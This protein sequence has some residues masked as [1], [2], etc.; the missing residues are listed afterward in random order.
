[1]TVVSPV[2]RDRAPSTDRRLGVPWALVVPLAALFAAVDGFWAASMRSAVG[3][4]ERTPAPFE[5]W[6][7]QTVVTLPL[8]VVAVVAAL[9]LAVRWFGPVPRGRRQLWTGALVALAGAVVGALVLALGAAVD[10]RLQQGHVDLMSHMTPGCGAPC[11][12]RIE[13][14]GVSTAVRGVAWGTGLVVVSNLAVVAWVMAALGG[15]LPVTRRS[16]QAD[17]ARW[18][19]RTAGLAAALAGSAAIHL[20]V[21]PEHLDEWPLA[22]AFF[23][24]LAAGEGGA[25]VAVLRGRRTTPPEPRRG[26]VAA[27]EQAGT[28]LQPRRGA[29]AAG[30][31]AGTRPQPRRGAV[32]AGDVRSHRLLIAAVLLGVGPLL[33][34]LVSRTVGLPFGP[35]AGEVEAVG[36]A[37]LA[38]VA[39]ELVTVCL[40]ARMLLLSTSAADPIGP[41]D[42]RSPAHVR[43]LAVT[44]VL[45]V[46]VVGCAGALPD[47]LGDVTGPATTVTV[48]DHG[49]DEGG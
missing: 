4:I 39:L 14:D 30:E 26:A 1:M 22:G 47:L 36:Q 15:R 6:A 11:L 28:R 46:T 40:A 10:L 49:H 19:A 12:E 27:G 25:A 29:V 33:V 37:D 21:V 31:Q 48:P 20:A 3:A 32:A 35:G 44:A 13:A 17:L 41:T 2:T 16:R 38:A 24:V 8:H 18:D 7:H 45:A 34:W 23:V 43:A 5:T 9:A 42:R